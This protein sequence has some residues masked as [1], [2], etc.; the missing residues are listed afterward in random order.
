MSNVLQAKE[1]TEFRR[2]ALTNIRREGNIPAVVYGVNME[3]KPIYVKRAP[4][5]SSNQKSGPQRAYVS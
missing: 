3:A 5:F 2:S 1:R 4:V